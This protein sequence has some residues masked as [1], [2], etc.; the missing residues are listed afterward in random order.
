MTQREFQELTDFQLDAEQYQCIE[1]V[2]MTVD[3]DKQ[4]LCAPLKEIVA[5]PSG[6]AAMEFMLQ[7]GRKMIEDEK[8]KLAEIKKWRTERDDLAEFLFDQFECP[9]ETEIKD[10]CKRVFGVNEFYAK[11]LR[12]G[13]ELS[14]DDLDDIADMLR[15]INR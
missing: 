8:K 11:S 10:K 12:E 5:G 4:Y 7:L 6:T 9:D 1:K 3:D 15:S 14:G 2:Y 13:K